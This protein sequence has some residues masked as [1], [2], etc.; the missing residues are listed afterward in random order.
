[1]Q[2]LIFCFIRYI[3]LSPQEVTDWLT[4]GLIS[5]LLCCQTDLAVNT[6]TVMH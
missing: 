4:E 6:V 1:M 2:L 3:F 5:A